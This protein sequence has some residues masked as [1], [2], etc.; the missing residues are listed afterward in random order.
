[1][2]CPTT[3]LSLKVTLVQQDHFGTKFEARMEDVAHP[4]DN[5]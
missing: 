2:H 1:M 4:E 5:H 3:V